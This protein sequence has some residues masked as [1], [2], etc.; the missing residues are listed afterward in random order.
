MNELDVILAVN[1][2][3][4]VGDVRVLTLTAAALVGAVGL[5]AVTTTL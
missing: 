4:F 1:S 2:V 5:T 3:G